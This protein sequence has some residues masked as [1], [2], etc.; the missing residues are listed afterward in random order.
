MLLWKG[1]GETLFR[2]VDR[3]GNVRVNSKGACSRDV[4]Q[5][6][7][8]HFSNARSLYARA[9]FRF[10]HGFARFRLNAGGTYEFVRNLVNARWRSEWRQGDRPACENCLSNSD[11]IDVHT[12]RLTLCICTAIDHPSPSRYQ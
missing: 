8:D 6:A 1:M 4:M 9:R 11:I 12:P 10:L 2:L 7:Q 5:H 3:S